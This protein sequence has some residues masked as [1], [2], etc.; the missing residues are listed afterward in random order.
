MKQRIGNIGQIQLLPAQ[1]NEN[2][3]MKLN[4]EF[5][6]LYLEIFKELLNSHRELIFQFIRNLLC[7]V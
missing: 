7:L 4:V 6:P 5:D 2:S 3:G 1:F